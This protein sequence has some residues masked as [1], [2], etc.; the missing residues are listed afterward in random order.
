[1]EFT[2][3]LSSVFFCQ[4]ICPRRKSVSSTL[5]NKCRLSY[6]QGHNNRRNQ[7]E[8]LNYMNMEATT[9][10]LYSLNYSHSKTY[11]AGSLFI[12]GN[13]ILPQ[14][15]HLIPQAG[16]IFLPIYFK[17]IS[18]RALLLVTLFYQLIGTCVERLIVGN[19]N[20]AIQDLRIGIPGILLQVFGG[21]FF[22]KYLIRN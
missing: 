8:F 10:K 7:N 9:I 3:Q 22:I 13:L 16:I 20:V 18:I 12:L 14:L 19:F 5:R 17:R 11:L 15:C 4:S 1:M 2:N 21:F 6:A